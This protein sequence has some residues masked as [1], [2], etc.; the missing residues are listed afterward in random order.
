MT[1]APVFASYVPQYAAQYAT[2]EPYLTP[3]D[4]LA[5]GTGTD[6]SQ[7]I[8]GGGP[9]ATMAALAG[10]ITRAS[11][12]ADN[13]IQSTIAA[14]SDVQVSPPEG[15]RIQVLGGR[16][17]VRVP[18]DNT[19]LIAVLGVSLGRT[20][21][22]VT[23]LTD[24]TGVWAARKVATIPIGNLSAS[25]TGTVPGTGPSSPS[26][27]G[28]VWG[29]LTYSDGF[30]NSTLA[31]PVSAGDASITVVT[32]TGLYPGLTIPLYDTAAGHDEPCR[33]GP[34]YVYGS[35]TVPL[36]APLAYAHAAGCSVSA[37]PPSVRDAVISLTTALLKR[38]GSGAM[39][40]QTAHG[41]MAV[42]G[43]P[44]KADEAHARMLL[45]S[46]ARS[47]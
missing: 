18:V 16:S 26:V 12:T 3:A 39:V 36:L 17:V 8:P 28:R 24:L 10:L 47:R 40:I 9:G 1:A 21:D 20:P 25:P 42:Q 31:A 43:D 38:R 13:M 5:A 35:T 27:S 30:F 41:E 34:G 14:T 37:L 32:P 6:T 2:T 7:L 33:V 44:G 29:S 4:Y 45:Q 46:L 11:S 15:W 22:T 23:P 19:P